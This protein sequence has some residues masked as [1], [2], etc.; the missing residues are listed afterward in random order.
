M[1]DNVDNVSDD[2]ESEWLENSDL[3]LFDKW[4]EKKAVII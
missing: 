2:E 1:A 4:N 3:R